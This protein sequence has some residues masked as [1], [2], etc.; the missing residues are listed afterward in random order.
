MN[1]SDISHP[2]F[3]INDG[4]IKVLDG[5]SP[6]VFMII[7]SHVDGNLNQISVL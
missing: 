4:Y 6:E 5:N 1:T 3:T 7:G 2:L